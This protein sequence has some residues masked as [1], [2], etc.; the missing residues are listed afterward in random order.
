MENEKYVVNLLVSV[1]DD[2]RQPLAL[3][4]SNRFN[5]ALDKMDKRL[6]QPGILT[7]PLGK[8]L[9]DSIAEMLI[10]A[11]AKVA[12][13]RDNLSDCLIFEEDTITS[14]DQISLRDLL[15]DLPPSVVRPAAVVTSIQRSRPHVVELPKVSRPIEV[16]VFSLLFLI[17]TLIFGVSFT[18]P[19]VSIDSPLQTLV[20][21]HQVQVKLQVMVPVSIRR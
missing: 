9:A 1:P 18:L 21:E 20:T 2:L 3:Q 4:L 19:E 11:D 10:Q 8:A 12:V 16:G 14:Q 7:K 15:A 13:V 5:L 17:L 6:C